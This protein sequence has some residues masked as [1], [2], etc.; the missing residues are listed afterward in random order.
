MSQVANLSLKNVMLEMQD[1]DSRNKWIKAVLKEQNTETSHFISLVQNQENVKIQH[2]AWLFTFRHEK[3]TRLSNNT[4][5]IKKSLKVIK[6]ER[7][8]L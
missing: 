8:G 4:A 5:N 6:E 2:T 1:L 7:N 3:A